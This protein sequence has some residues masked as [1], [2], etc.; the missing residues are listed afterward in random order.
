MQRI[1]HDSSPIWSQ[2]EP[3]EQQWGH[4]QELHANSLNAKTEEGLG[5]NTA[6]ISH[7]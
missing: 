3:L 5:F 1:V 2:E 7:P 4:S 6:R